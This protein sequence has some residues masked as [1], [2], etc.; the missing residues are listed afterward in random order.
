MPDGL[1]WVFQKQLIY[2]AFHSQPSLGF[3]EN[4]PKK[5]KV[6]SELQFCGRKCLEDGQRRMTRLVWADRKATVT[7]ITPHYNQG[8]QKS[9]SECM[10][11]QTLKQMSYSSRRAH[12]VPLLTAKN[13]KPRHKLA[14]NWTIEDWK[15]VACSHESQFLLQH[16]E[17]GTNIES[18]DLSCLVSMVQAAAVV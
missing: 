14:K 17:F 11:H 8:M 1:D 15:K 4:A 13:R 16:S 6:S 5:R 7:Q 18:M 2:W 10:T 9:I 3:T 12:R